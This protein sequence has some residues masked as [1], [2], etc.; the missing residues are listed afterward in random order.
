MGERAAFNGANPPTGLEAKR[1]HA[2]VARPRDENERLELFFKNRMGDP[3]G[4]IERP[5]VRTFFVIDLHT[6]QHRHDGIPFTLQ[7]ALERLLFAFARNVGKA[8]RE[9]AWW[10][11]LLA[12][13]DDCE[14]D[15]RQLKLYVS[16]LRRA[17]AAQTG[18]PLKVY[19][20]L[21][22]VERGLWAF[23]I[24]PAELVLRFPSDGADCNA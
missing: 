4:S 12:L 22:R 24:S 23:Q 14:S 19:K 18:I 11:I 6:H 13:G 3:A 16:R 7:P 8:L 1:L 10:E 20:E 5:A 2:C 9:H 17:I 21:F 15:T